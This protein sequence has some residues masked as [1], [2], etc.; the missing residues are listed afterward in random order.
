MNCW[1]PRT[2]FLYLYIQ[3]YYIT[4]FFIQSPTT[5]VWQKRWKH[6]T[7]QR[8]NRRTIWIQMIRMNSDSPKG[9]VQLEDNLRTYGAIVPVFVCMLIITLYWMSV[10]KDI[11][12][13]VVGDKIH[14]FRRSKSNFYTKKVSDVENSERSA[15][16]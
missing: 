1:P 12:K 7:T 10:Q 14:Y 8:M 13:Y 3:Q 5:D 6:N 2:I 9:S 4:E 11:E 16:K 15:K